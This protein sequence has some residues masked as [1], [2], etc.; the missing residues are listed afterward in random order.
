MRCNNV[1]E[2]IPYQLL[3]D[4]T[5]DNTANTV[6]AEATQTEAATTA[7]Q[8]NRQTRQTT[9]CHSSLFI[10]GGFTIPAG[11]QVQYFYHNANYT[12]LP[13][14]QLSQHPPHDTP[15]QFRKK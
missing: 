10:A 8:V 2:E 4:P 13:R 15:Q 14:Y 12:Q 6:P 5:T 1:H 11:T 9:G 7:K 3:Q